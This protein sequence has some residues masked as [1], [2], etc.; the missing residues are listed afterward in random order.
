MDWDIT[1]H[2]PLC[3]NK[4]HSCGQ[5]YTPSN[6]RCAELTTLGRLLDHVQAERSDLITATAT[7]YTLFNEFTELLCYR[8][9][10]LTL[11]ERFDGINVQKDSDV[12]EGK[13]GIELVL[14]VDALWVGGCFEGEVEE[15]RD[16]V[17]L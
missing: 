6:F 15:A 1:Y 4:C 7:R 9:G 8:P 11:G 3:R 16:E 14:G 12:D 13:H 10:S 17:D 2:S 5:D